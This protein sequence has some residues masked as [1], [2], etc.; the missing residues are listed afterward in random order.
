ML[1]KSAKAVS[2]H[3]VNH[4]VALLIGGRLVEGA[5]TMDVINPATAEPCAVAP[6]ASAAQLDEAIKLA[7][8]AQPAWAALRPEERG[9]R[10]QRLAAL[11]REHVEELAALLTLEQGRPLAQ[12]RTEVARA[13]MLLEAMLTID[14]G[15][16]LLRED[17][18]YRILLR[19]RPLG[20]V[21]AIA[22]WNVPIGLAVPKITHALYTGNTIVLKPSQYTPLATLRLGQYAAD[23]FPPGVLNIVNGG[24]DLGEAICSHPDV[25]KIT[26]T[27]SVATGKRVMATGANSLKRLTLELGGNDACIVRQ[28]ADIERI[29]PA[30]FAAAFVN[31]GQV[32]MAIKRLYVHESL[33]DRL[34]RRMTDLANGVK[35]GEGFDPSTELGPLQNAAQFESVRRVLGEVSADPSARV[36][37][38]GKII[39]RPGYFIEPTIVTGLAE[40]S[41]LVDNETFGP[42]L[43]ILSFG[44]DKEAIARANATSL[45]LGASVWGED[46]AHAE[47]VARQLDAGTVWINRHVGVDPLVPFGGNK[48]SGIG[49]QFGREGLLDFTESSALYVP[50]HG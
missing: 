24:N 20:V 14:I 45:G 43:P 34:A 27:G 17:D 4:P 6:V 49:R 47:Q 25:A 19:H 31:S 3:L 48:E 42:V 36:I 41:T 26:L 5:G 12:T 13:A 1:Y 8:H 28:D 44:T 21:G 16:E 40:G 2:G 9:R 29:A 39:D 32:C 35:V 7:R 46:I 22:P 23:I 11:L 38:G 33:H 10:L 30:L 18:A 37:A 15:D 50:Q